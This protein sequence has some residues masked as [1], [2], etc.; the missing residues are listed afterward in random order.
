MTNAELVEKIRRILDDPESASG[1]EQR[2]AAR[3]YAARVKRVEEGFGRAQARLN[4][5]ELC[6]ADRILTEN[7]LLSDFDSLTFSGA[8]DW[9]VV[10]RTFDYD[11]APSLDKGAR[12]RLEEFQRGY[13]E[14]R[15]V[16]ARRR[17]QAMENAPPRAQLETLY[18]LEGR[19]GTRGFL[20]RQIERLEKRRDAELNALV[21]DL[22]EETVLAIDF[23][24]IAAEINDPRRHS[25]VPPALLEQC[26]RWYEYYQGRREYARLRDLIERW[27]QAFDARDSGA[28]LNGLSE[29]RTGEFKRAAAFVTAEET[30][31]LTELVNQAL[32]LERAETLQEDARRKTDALRSALLRQTSEDERLHDLYEAATIACDVA[33]TSLPPSVEKDY[34]K[35]V[36]AI[37]ALRSRRRVAVVVFSLIVVAFFAALATL[38]IMHARNV[39]E[40]RA[41]AE[42]IAAQLDAFERRGSDAATALKTAGDLVAKFS[43]TR[44]KF[45]EVAEFAAVV[46]RCGVLQTEEKERLR[47]IDDLIDLIDAAHDSGK[48]D[49]ASIDKLRKLLLDDR[50]K[51]KY[52][53]ARRY[54]DDSQIRQ[55]GSKQSTGRYSELV[56]ELASKERALEGNAEIAQDDAKKAIREIRAGISDLKKLEQGAEIAQP[57]LKARE[58]LETA[59]DGTERRLNLRFAFAK[60]GAELN[61]AL[62]DAARYRKALQTIRDEVA[63]SDSEGEEGGDAT[64]DAIVRQLDAAIADVANVAR[65]DAWNKFVAARPSVNATAMNYAAYQAAKKELEKT[66]SPVAP[67]QAEFQKS[68]ER[69]AGF[70]KRGGYERAAST[71]AES[72]KKYATPSWVFYDSKEE[73]YFYLTTDPRAGAS[74]LKYF[75]D[76]G[77]PGKTKDFAADGFDESKVSS[78]PQ[79]VQHAI[80]KFASEKLG[81]NA[82]PKDWFDVVERALLELDKAPESALDPTVKMLLLADALDS[83][84]DFPG[85]EEL[86]EWLE[87]A[88]KNSDFD[89]DANPYQPGKEAATQRQNATEALRD[90]PDAKKALETAKTAFEEGERAEPEYRWVGRIETVDSELR[91]VLGEGKSVAAGTTLWVAR[92][93]D[94][95]AEQ[96]GTATESGAD[97]NGA[98][99][100]TDFSW[101]PVYARVQK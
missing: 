72:L 25:P 67:E 101:T 55:S 92:G 97:F 71:L 39:K 89:F 78:A 30:E 42:S 23:D 80:A 79:S 94:A 4:A 32:A 27:R 75:S 22:N 46:E 14:T 63:A 28:V 44:P 84:E 90:L 26:A 17:R 15:D 61:A 38:S 98:K 99:D 81:A 49:P 12:D 37:N 64:R 82:T 66:T 52:D 57:L 3:V 40:A 47:T 59:L 48:A 86:T 29:Y 85:F 31:V 6:D 76:L 70:A 8:A 41:A 34:L 18:A 93:A 73:R 60:R 50:E 16:F 88:R 2:E 20:T 74:R 36:G 51:T 95:L 45:A 53:Y 7:S 9:Q 13:A 43:E 5:D 77:D 87:D 56:D 21:R 11:V 68:A 91:L 58:A 62:G 69:F 19:L 54:R 33:G 83:A 24:S 1:D 100:W 96:A 35:Q 10:C 65:V